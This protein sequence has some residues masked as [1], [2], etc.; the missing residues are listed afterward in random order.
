MARAAT[1][2]LSTP[3]PLLQRREQVGLS[4]GAYHYNLELVD[5]TPAYMRARARIRGAITPIRG[6]YRVLVEGCLHDADGHEDGYRL[7]FL[8]R[9]RTI[10]QREAAGELFRGALGSAKRWLAEAVGAELE[11]LPRL[12]D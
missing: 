2:A 5:V 4:A 12:A 7:F 6:G 11:A 8:N 10:E 1:A 9:E 3:A